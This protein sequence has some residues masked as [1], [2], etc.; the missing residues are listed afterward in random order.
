MRG[1]SSETDLEEVGFFVS[2]RIREKYIELVNLQLK[3]KGV[4]LD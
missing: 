2:E 4:I 1:A 3:N